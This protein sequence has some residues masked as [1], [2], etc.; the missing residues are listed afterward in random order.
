[1][2]SRPRL[3]SLLT[4]MLLSLPLGAAEGARVFPLWDGKET[5]ASYAERVKLPATK[6]LDLGGGVTLDL[7]LIPAGQFIMGSEEPK[8]PT[9]TKEETNVPILVGAICI[10]LLVLRWMITFRKTRKF[11]FSLRWLLL[12]TMATGAFI[13]GNA[14]QLL[15]DK[16][17]LQYL[18]EMKEYDAL[19]SSEKLAH[20]VTLTQPF[21][22]GKYTVTQ[23]QYT[24]IMGNNP[25]H[26][27]GAQL[28]VERV[29]WEDATTFCTKLNEL[30]KNKINQARLPTE[31]QWEYACRAGTRTRFYSGNLDSD[32]NVAGW[33]DSNSGYTTH[34]VGQLKA[35]AFGLYD[36]HGNVFHWCQDF[37]EDSYSSTNPTQNPTGPKQG[38]S[39]VLRG[40]SWSD[41]PD[42]CRSAYRDGITPDV[43]YLNF[44]FRVVISGLDF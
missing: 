10:M 29:S 11:S 34:P 35:N 24:A 25:S 37:W 38:I 7:V 20:S 39:R 22:M 28:P 9:I 40:G 3:M 44:G 13:G 42:Y 5:V 43:R 32:L 2:L 18:K 17:T 12:M 8:V 33:F 31:A 14:R 1:M 4:L 23:A 6:S 27:K 30:L 15:A 16:E 36:M 26:L 21:Y 41:P 19:P